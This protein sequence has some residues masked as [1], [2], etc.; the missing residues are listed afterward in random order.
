LD[1][2]CAALTAREAALGDWIEVGVFDAD[3]VRS[4][5]PE[6]RPTMMTEQPEGDR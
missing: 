1:R 5:K 3:G 6:H 2:S 4:E